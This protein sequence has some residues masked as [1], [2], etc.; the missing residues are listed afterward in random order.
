MIDA[1]NLEIKTK[2]LLKLELIVKQSIPILPSR[3]T[4]FAIIKAEKDKGVKFYEKLLK[5]KYRNLGIYRHSCGKDILYSGHLV[6]IRCSPL[7]VSP[8]VNILS[9]L[10]GPQILF[11]G[12]SNDVDF[13]DIDLEL[14]I[15]ENNLILE[16]I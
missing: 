4:Y 7:E 9:N 3:N 5:D 12:Y 14:L 10:K 16:N 15:N 13:D 8:I 2:D 11:V 6:N 1:E